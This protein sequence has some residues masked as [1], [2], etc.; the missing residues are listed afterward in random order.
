MSGAASVPAKW[1]STKVDASGVRTAQVSLLIHAHVH[2]NN[3]V[4]APTTPPTERWLRV[5]VFNLTTPTLGIFNYVNCETDVKNSPTS[6]WIFLFAYKF[7]PNLLVCFDP[8]QNRNMYG[9]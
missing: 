5:E 1:W 9:M 7:T 4:I 8:P 2:L 6:P 3:V